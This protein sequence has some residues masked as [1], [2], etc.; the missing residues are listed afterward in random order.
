MDSAF[1]SFSVRDIA[2]WLWQLAFQ[3]QFYMPLT[4]FDYNPFIYHTNTLQKQT[5][6]SWSHGFWQSLLY[7]VVRPLVTSVTKNNFLIS[8]P[9][10]MLWVL[11][12]TVS[13]RWFFWAPKDVKNDG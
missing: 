5:F 13:M 6:F 3:V 10:Y 4:I 9:K 11:K 1:P 7:M 2:V 12:R 8:Q